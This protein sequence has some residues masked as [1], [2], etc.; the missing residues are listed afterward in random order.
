[1]AFFDDLSKKLSQASQSAVQKAKEMTDIAR[2]NGAI[3]DEEKKINNSYYQ[4]GKLYVSMHETDYED[5]FAAVIA[6]IK[7]SE[8][9]ICEYKQQL[10]D[11]KG[12]VRCEKCGAEVANNVAFCSACGAAMPKKAEAPSEDNAVK[13]EGCGAVIS[14]NV[15]FCTSCGR[16]VAESAQ[17]AEQNDAETADNAQEAKSSRCSNCG[18][19]LKEGLAFCTGCGTKLN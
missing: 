1:M 7:E 15:R 4:I 13:C 17:E 14:K 9:K 8:A 11:I 6:A 18:A 16:P 10:Q 12:V 19:E 5:N 2:I 3:S